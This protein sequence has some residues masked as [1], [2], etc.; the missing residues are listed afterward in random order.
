MPI[1]C[2]NNRARKSSMPPVIRQKPRE[3]TRTK[4]DDLDR[5]TLILFEH[6]GRNDLG[7]NSQVISMAPTTSRPCA[8]VRLQVLPTTESQHARCL[9][10][11]DDRTFVG[12]I[13][14]SEM[15]HDQAIDWRN[16]CQTLRS[17][18]S[19]K[20][21]QSF[22]FCVRKQAG[23]MIMQIPGFGKHMRTKSRPR[24]LERSNQ[25]NGQRTRSRSKIEN[26]YAAAHFTGSVVIQSNDFASFS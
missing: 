22:H 26:S 25:A 23:K 18:D 6:P 1:R 21:P 4:V 17:I 13:S 3:Q 9:L 5:E 10:L 11:F 19:P 15:C 2:S 20:A 16:D 14:S 8:T 24:T 12:D 7:A